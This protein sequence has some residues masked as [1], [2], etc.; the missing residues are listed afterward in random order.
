LRGF[1]YGDGQSFQRHAR[2]P[3]IRRAAA[4]VDDG[5]GGDRQRPGCTYDFDHFF[6]AAAGRNHVFDYENPLTGRERESAA[7][8]HSPVGVAFR[9]KEPDTKRPRDFV[10]DNQAAKSGGNHQIGSLSGNQIKKRR[11]KTFAETF[12][13]LRMLQHQR[14]LQVSGAMKSA[15]KPEVALQISA[16]LYKKVE[17]AVRLRR[18]KRLLYHWEL[19]SRAINTREP[20][21]TRRRILLLGEVQS[22]L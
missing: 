22:L 13:V 3:E 7:Q 18:H 4:A 2:Y 12:G 1:K 17:N 6:C 21:P 14:G 11:G 15:R 16:C 19:T 8:G 20:N 5:T 10:S 9:E